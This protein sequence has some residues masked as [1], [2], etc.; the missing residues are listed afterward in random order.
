MNFS[1]WKLEEGG[2]VTRHS[3]DASKNVFFFFPNTSLPGVV[4][5]VAASSALPLSLPQPPC[6]PFSPPVESL[7]LLILFIYC[8]QVF[9]ISYSFIL[10]KHSHGLT[11]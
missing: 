2:Y 4:L 3:A 5:S 6:P 8:F 10:G 1:G 9:L 11:F 7:L